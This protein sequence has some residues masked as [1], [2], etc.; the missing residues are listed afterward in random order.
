MFEIPISLKYDFSSGRKSGWFST[1]GISSYLMKK[2]D[3][4]YQYYYG[5]SGPVPH[6]KVYSTTTTQLFASVRLSGGY[7]HELGRIGSLRVEPYL[8]L[9]ISGMGFGKVKMISTGMH[10]GIVKKLW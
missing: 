1:A 5:T 8:S 4:T 9:P 2:E 7:Q 6:R 3:Y 10:V